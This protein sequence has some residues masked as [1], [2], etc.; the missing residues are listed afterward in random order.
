MAVRAFTFGL[1]LREE[2]KTVRVHAPQGSAG[3]FVVEESQP[4]GRTQ[5]REHGSAASAVRDSAARW[6]MRLN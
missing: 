6:R 1:R 4:G 2:G 5:R 3:K